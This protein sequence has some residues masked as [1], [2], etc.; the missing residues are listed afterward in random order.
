MTNPR[1]LVFLMLGAGIV[2][3][4]GEEMSTEPTTFAL[5]FAPVFEGSEV[6][7]TSAL[8]GLGTNA[9]NSVGIADLRFYVS[10]LKLYDSAGNQLTT[11]LDTNEFQYV[12]DAGTVTLID[13][14]GDAGTCGASAIANA[15]GTA[16]TNESIKGTVDGTVRRVAFDVGLP[17]SLMKDVISTKT[18][19]DA[20]SPLGE[21]YWSWASGYRHFVFNFTVTNEQAESGEGYLHIGSRDCGGDGAKALTDRDAC[22]LVYT[23][24]VSLDDFDPATNRVTVDLGALLQGLDL[25]APIRDSGPAPRRHR[26][27][28]RRFLS[29]HADGGGLPD[30]LLEP[31][32][33]HDLRQRDPQHEPRVR[34]RVAGCGAPTECERSSRLWSSPV[35]PRAG[36]A[37]LR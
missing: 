1:R 36:T 37:I 27:G 20:P 26:H 31:R 23:P 22:G 4:G 16:R 34:R 6:G 18:A 2:G 14:T 3:C 33:R 10:N 12:G 29:L 21:M 8:T 32:P 9:D 17:Q 28:T 30:R 19:E 35:R 15:E 11:T 5:S 7:C 24:S 25:V 13:L